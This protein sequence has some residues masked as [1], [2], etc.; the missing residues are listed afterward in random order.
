MKRTFLRGTV[1]APKYEIGKP[2]DFKNTARRSA[3]LGSQMAKF[4]VCNV[5]KS[6]RRAD[7]SYSEKRARQMTSAYVV[8]YDRNGD[9]Q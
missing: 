8:V 6:A 9:S 1:A 7:W 2:G 3:P 4:E 5:M